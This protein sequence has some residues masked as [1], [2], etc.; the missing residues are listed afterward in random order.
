M[1]P[2]VSRL[3]FHFQFEDYAIIGVILLMLVGVGIACHRMVGS[4]RDFLIGGN[5]MSW[6]L[7]GMSVFMGG[8][9]AWTFTGA[10]GLAYTNGHVA[11]LY[12]LMGQGAGF[13][14]SALFIAHRCRQTRKLTTMEIVNSRFG[15]TTE[16][17]VLGL[18]LLSAIPMG[19]IWLTGL[20]LFFSVAFAVPMAPC[21]LVAGTIILVYSTLGGSWAIATSDFF[22]GIL[23][24]LMVILV[25]GL[26]LGAIGGVGGLIDHV[27]P[28][29][30]RGFDAEHDVLWLLAGG[31]FT[32]VNFSSLAGGPRD[33]S[34]VDGRA[35]RKVAALASGLFVIGPILWFLPPIVATYVFPD[36]QSSLPHLKHP[37]EG[38]YVAMGLSVLPAGLAGLLLVNIFGA[39]LTA[40][41]AAV[42]QTAGFLTVNVYKVWIRP[43][44]SDRETV[45]TARICSV[46]F[47][48]IVMALALALAQSEKSSLLELNLNVQS[49]VA[50]P[51]V[52]PF[53]LLWFARRAPRW[54]AIASIVVGIL[55]SYSLNKNVYWPSLP[56]HVEP[57]L[58][59]LAGFGAWEAGRPF[60]FAVRVFIVLGV[61]VSV[62]LGTRIFWR[63]GPDSGRRAVEAFYAE[64][65]RPIETGSATGRE[66]PRQFVIA[67]VLLTITGAVLLLLGAWGLLKGSSA[68]ITLCFG[69]AVLVVGCGTFSFGR[70]RARRLAADRT[71]PAPI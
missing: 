25:A 69:L 21:I 16:Q 51:I 20:A 31:A 38:A 67:G 27:P 12:F 37:Q 65:D 54:A 35:A 3:E 52:V 19:A 42:N 50:I 6:W 59:S 57:G 49:I 4:T 61:C 13:L 11:I 33:L 18:Q 47:G 23:L 17:L 41:D 45:L 43:N 36:L 28:R 8:F 44:A 10:A 71:K 39:T 46:I 32:F 1:T 15:R 53:F 22:Q 48:C 62:F 30:M 2:S 58:A 14:F 66:D 63:K 29:V 56:G 64:M 9:S 40:L 70:V 24:L 7:A 5:R 34:V 55:V 26:S 68:A 60:P